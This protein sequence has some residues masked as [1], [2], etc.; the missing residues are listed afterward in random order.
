MD[1]RTPASTPVAETPT[2]N[3]TITLPAEYAARVVADLKALRTAHPDLSTPAMHVVKVRLEVALS[4]V[5]PAPVTSTGGALTGDVTDPCETQDEPATMAIVTRVDDLDPEA[6]YA[7]WVCDAEMRRPGVL[8]NACY[9]HSMRATGN[10][11]EM[12][13]VMRVYRHAYAELL[14]D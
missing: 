11:A 14:N 4:N 6:R 10:G 2:G 9:G 12:A 1:I 3:V 13:A 5:P 8:H 7:L